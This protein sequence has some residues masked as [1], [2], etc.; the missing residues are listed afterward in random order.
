MYAQVQLFVVFL[1]WFTIKTIFCM[2]CKSHATSPPKIYFILLSVVGSIS[3]FGWK[4]YPNE[5]AYF[6]GPESRICIELSNYDR[7]HSK[8]SKI[9]KILSVSITE[10][11]LQ[12]KTWGKSNPGHAVFPEIS[13][14]HCLPSLHLKGY[15]P[16]S[17]SY[18]LHMLWTVFRHL[19]WKMR[20]KDHI[21]S[22]Y[23]WV[24]AAFCMRKSLEQTFYFS[25]LLK[26]VQSGWNIIN[27]IL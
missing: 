9:V 20:E 23:G 2:L 22:L 12:A 8:V 21:A 25:L 19:F 6:S 17:F 1:V 16:D 14:F 3:M 13:L 10:L 26:K 24:P 11:I 15:Q 7:K 27:Y 18:G 4:T 5:T